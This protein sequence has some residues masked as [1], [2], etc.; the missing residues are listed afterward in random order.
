V[1]LAAGGILLLAPWGA[2]HLDLL[3]AVFAL[4][5]GAFWAAYIYLSQRVGRLF[6]GGAGLALAMVGGGVALLPVGI[7]AAGPALLQPEL[8]LGGLAVAVLSSVV[9][10]SLEMEAL[11]HLHT[12]VFGVLMSS[13]PAVAAIFG[14]LILRQVLDL[15]AIVAILLVSAASLGASRERGPEDP[16]EID[17]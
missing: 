13:E 3:G 15:R 17:V 14:F 2:F 5:A 7:I 6:P 10:Y 4:L 9:P 12:R 1:A 16:V 8:L 11:R